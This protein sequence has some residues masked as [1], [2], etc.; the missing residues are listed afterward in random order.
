VIS[1]EKEIFKPD[2]LSSRATVSLLL[3][4]GVKG[5]AT[6]SQK[7]LKLFSHEKMV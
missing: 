4:F 5:F 3:C 1:V 7:A 2:F 6:L